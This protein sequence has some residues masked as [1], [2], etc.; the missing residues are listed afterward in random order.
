MAVSN[1]Y[2]P[3]VACVGL[4]ALDPSHGQAPPCGFPEFKEQD[5]GVLLAAHFL[6]VAWL[7]PFSEPLSCP[8][9]GD[10]SCYLNRT[11]PVRTNEGN[12]RVNSWLQQIESIQISRLK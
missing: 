12:L 2:D 8:L 7:P 10:R 3:M 1:P 4:G 5:L 6:T 11:N 9:I